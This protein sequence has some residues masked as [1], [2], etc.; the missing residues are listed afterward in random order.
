MGAMVGTRLGPYEIVAP[1][2][3]G[4]MG[5]VYRA[6]DPRLG[7]DVAVKVLPPPPPAT[8]IGWPGSSGRRARSPASRIPNLLAIF[9]VGTGDPPYLVTELLDGET[10]RSRLARGP[11]DQGDAIGLALQMA[12]GLAA[13]HARGVVHRD[14]KPANIFVTADGRAE[15]PRLRSRH[16]R[17]RWRP[18]QHR[19]PP[20]RARCPA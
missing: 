1:I 9:D 19:R 18:D 3:A 14:L 20:P 8:P 10:L 12:A 2:G 13:A 7:R 4:G 5:E 17:G 15:D 6:R 16:H 11:L